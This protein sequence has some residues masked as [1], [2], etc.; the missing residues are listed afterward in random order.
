MFQVFPLCPLALTGLYNCLSASPVQLPVFF[1]GWM[2]KYD[3][4]Q[5][6]FI[7]PQGAIKS[8][9]VSWCVES[10]KTRLFPDDEETSDGWL[11]HLEPK[12]GR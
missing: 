5:K 12:A 9:C 7:D 8:V 3:Q 1:S 11:I 6:D 4:N 2:Q 10:G